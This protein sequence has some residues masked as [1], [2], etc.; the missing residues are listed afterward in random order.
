MIFNIN[1]Y[2]FILGYILIIIFNISYQIK[3]IN[4]FLLTM[5]KRTNFENNYY[6]ISDNCSPLDYSINPIGSLY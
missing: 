5:K 2:L 4:Q 6:T 3:I 1:F